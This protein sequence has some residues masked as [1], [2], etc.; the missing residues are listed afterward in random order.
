MDTDCRGCCQESWRCLNS[1]DLLALGRGR[2]AEPGLACCRRP[3]LKAALAAALVPRA[4]PTGFV[5][6]LR[7]TGGMPPEGGR[8]LDACTITC[9]LGRGEAGIFHQ[10]WQVNMAACRNNIRVKQAKSMGSLVVK[11][12][13]E[14]SQFCNSS[15]TARLTTG[16]YMLPS[17][18]SF[19]QYAKARQW[20]QG[21]QFMAI[22]YHCLPCDVQ[23]AE[24]S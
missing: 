2:D 5:N 18:W 14:I 8:P 7:K 10:A 20:L 3:L 12:H 22:T 11:S 17:L 13:G 19:A 21:I 1:D 24:A 23:G 6:A 16:T 15:L 9:L 4:R